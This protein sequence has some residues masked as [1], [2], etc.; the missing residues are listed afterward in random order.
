V[1]ELRRITEDCGVCLGLRLCMSSRAVHVHH[2]TLASDGRE[3]MHELAR[4][5]RCTGD[6]D[7]WTGRLRARVGSSEEGRRGVGDETRSGPGR[8][9]LPIVAVRTT[10]RTARW[11][12]GRRLEIAGV[13][14]SA[15]RTCLRI[16]RPQ[17]LA[18]Q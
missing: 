17:Q 16:S 10:M 6:C 4:L 15:T 1:R 12:T 8:T 11:C 5:N 3:L 2:A 13:S 18:C 14:L 9:R 7:G